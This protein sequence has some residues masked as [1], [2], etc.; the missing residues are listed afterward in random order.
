[1]NKEYIFTSERLGFRNWTDQD[2]E[3]MSQI[4]SD[5]DVME[6]FPSLQTKEYTEG[7]I[8]RM[9]NEFKERNYCYFA[10]EIKNTYEFIGFI[11]LHLQTFEAD[12]TPCVDIGW[13]L[14]KSV[15]NQGYATEGALRC[16]AYARDDLKIN[17]VYSIT[18]KINIRSERIMQ[19][20][21]MQKEKEFVFELLKDDERLKNCV[22]Y[23]KIF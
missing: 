23:S 6:F 21:G 17:R 1:M 22:L 20:A 13:R 14:K 15:W 9:Q 2:L 12:F 10:V 4:S 8:K 19:K 18:P 7:F 5:E 3:P 16:L 11:G